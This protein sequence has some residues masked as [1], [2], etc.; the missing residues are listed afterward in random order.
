MFKRY[1]KY[2]FV[3]VICFF[4]FVVLF[5]L[6]DAN[7]KKY[8]GNG[9]A[10]IIQEKNS[11]YYEVLNEKGVYRK[12]I[13]DVADFFWTSTTVLEN[14]TFSVDNKNNIYYLTEEDIKI[15]NNVQK[16]IMSIQKIGE[17]NILIC[18]K[19]G[20]VSII[21]Y[22]DGFENINNVTEVD[23]IFQHCFVSGDLLYYTVYSDK[24]FSTTVYEYNTNTDD[25]KM[26]Y[27]NKNEREEIYPFVFQDEIY[28]AKNKL[29]KESWNEMIQSIYNIAATGEIIKIMDIPA[30]LKK[31]VCMENSLYAL[32]GVNTTR[33]VE[34]N[35]EDNSINNLFSKEEEPLG[36][37]CF[38]SGLNIATNE[39]I[40]ELNEYEF[41][42]IRSINMLRV[43]NEFR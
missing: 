13:G 38:N 10:Y 2:A 9:I 42:K 43:N 24:D 32:L 14:E 25:N 29:I 37:F 16:G 11:C 35:I 23:G 1:K 19:E 4:V 5:L 34:I 6:K 27:F 39:G 41:L 18:E 15:F 8:K 7:I 31:V 30:P 3:L 20:S 40:Y 21:K 17:F 33:V 28:I 36:L 22:I 12:K 26:V